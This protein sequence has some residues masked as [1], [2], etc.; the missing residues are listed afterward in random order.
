MTSRF[1]RIITMVFAA[2][3]FAAPAA[4]SVGEGVFAHRAGNAQVHVEESGQ[5]D[6]AP[7][8]SADCAICR[9]L[10]DNTG[11]VPS[12]AV[13][14]AIVAD[15]PEPVVAVSVGASADGD[16]FDA[17]GPPAIAG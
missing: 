5:K 7:P 8:H 11:A 3:Q 15:Q 4:A 2:I 6:C 1:A 17:R 9:Y 12:A 16:G 13:L 10:V 14:V